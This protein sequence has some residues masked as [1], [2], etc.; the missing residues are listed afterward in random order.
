MRFPVKQGLFGRG[1]FFR[2]ETQL[3]ER[4]QAVLQP[5]VDHPVQIGEAEPLLPFEE[6]RPEFLPDSHLV[7]EQAVSAD[8]TETAFFLHGCH[9]VLILLLERQVHP[10]GADTIISQV[11]ELCC[12]SGMNNDLPAHIDPPVFQ[13]R[14]QYIGTE[15]V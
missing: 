13:F 9:L 2:H 10:A 5:G 11:P 1:Q 4:L 15:T 8:V 6:R 14:V 3:K 12:V 7:A